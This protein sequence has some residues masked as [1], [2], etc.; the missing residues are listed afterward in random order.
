MCEI[1]PLLASKIQTAPCGFCLSCTGSL[2]FI[3]E[4]LGPT[5]ERETNQIQMIQHFDQLELNRTGSRYSGSQK[6]A[7]CPNEFFDVSAESSNLSTETEITNLT[8]SC[9][10]DRII[11]HVAVFAGSTK[12]KD[13]PSRCAPHLEKACLRQALAVWLVQ[14]H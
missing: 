9:C 11:Q 5:R 1:H 14:I 13:A 10:R 3:N 4:P 2:F 6:I 8:R 7:R 12:P